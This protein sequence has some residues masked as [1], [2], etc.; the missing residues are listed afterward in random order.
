MESKEFIFMYQHNNGALV[1]ESSDGEKYIKFDDLPFRTI[2]EVNE[3]IQRNI[4]RLN[5]QKAKEEKIKQD[6]HY[7]TNE[8]WLN[9]KG[10]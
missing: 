9:L 8:D 7:L 6:S 1:Y 2:G 5:E 3:Y 10:E 4:T